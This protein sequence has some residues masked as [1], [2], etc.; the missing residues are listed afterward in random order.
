MCVV[1]NTGDYWRDTFIPRWPDYTPTRPLIDQVTRQEFDDLKKEVAELVK[2]LKAA[3]RFDEATGQPDCEM[4]DKVALI[5]RIAG[6][7]GVDLGDV[8]G[9]G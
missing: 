8:F 7:L 2:L 6:E 4:D 9:E 3:K 5:K 1:S